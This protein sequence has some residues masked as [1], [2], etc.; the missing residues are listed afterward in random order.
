MVSRR[1]ALALGCGA[2]VT[3]I[4]G[5]T[6]LLSDSSRL[7]L[8]ALNF[9]SEPHAMTVELLR[10]DADRYSEAVELRERYELEAPPDG[11]AAYEHR[12]PDTLENERYVVRADL[13][14]LPATRATYQYYPGCP[15]GDES[16]DLYVEVRTE[17][18]SDDR[19]IEF[20][21]NRCS[22]SS[23]WF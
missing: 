4:S 19:Y 9:D 23:G 20:T 11:D 6:G 2:G 1:D 8:I 15:D 21:Q 3:A 17:P 13:Q 7:S 22:G 18:E 5:C 14:D 12:E 16:D 10:A